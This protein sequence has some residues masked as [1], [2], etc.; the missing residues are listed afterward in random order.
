MLKAWHHLAYKY[1][2]YISG[3]ASCQNVHVWQPFSHRVT[4]LCCM[5][6]RCKLQPSGIAA[7]ACTYAQQQHD[8]ALH[9]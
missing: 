7:C 3:I 4:S 1:E 5:H 8:K 6:E 9:A 2:A